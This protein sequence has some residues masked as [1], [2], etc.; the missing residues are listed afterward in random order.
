MS[1]KVWNSIYRPPVSA[2]RGGIFA[3]AVSLCALALLHNKR[4][5]ERDIILLSNGR[6]SSTMARCSQIWGAARI[7]KARLRIP[8]SD[9]GP[10][11]SGA[12]AQVAHYFWIL[13]Y[14][15]PNPTS[16]IHRLPPPPCCAHCAKYYRNMVLTMSATFPVESGDE[17]PKRRYIQCAPLVSGIVDGCW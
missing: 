16:Q 5:A 12:Q 4:Q 7:G 8:G 2:Q 13:K 17:Q 9:G 6:V 15:H 11:R 1:I 14:L 3:R 10:R